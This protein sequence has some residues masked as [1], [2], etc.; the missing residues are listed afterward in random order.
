TSAANKATSALNKMAAAAKKAA[1]ARAS[2]GGMEHGGSFV[3]HAQKGFSGI[4]NRPTTYKGVRMGEGFKEEMITVT[5]LTRGTGNHMGPTVSSD[6]GSG[7]G[8]SNT[9][10]NFVIPVV[11]NNR[12]FG[13]AVKQ[14]TLE[15][16]GL[17]V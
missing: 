4:V 14:T 15:D 9:P 8:R 16:M 12:E 7:G 6:K 2:V 10:I 17:Q 1:A 3:T 11:I 13:R 5:P